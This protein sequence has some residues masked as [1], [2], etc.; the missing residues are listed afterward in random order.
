MSESKLESFQSKCLKSGEVIVVGPL[1]HGLELSAPSAAVLAVDGGCEHAVRFDLSIGDGDSSGFQMDIPASIHKNQSDLALAL[2]I[3]PQG[4]R[5]RLYGFWGQR[6]DHQLTVL[7]EVTRWHQERRQPLTLFGP[8]SERLEILPPGTHQIKHLGLFSLLSLYEGEFS[9]QGQLRYP[10]ER[11]RL[12][13]LS[14]Q[15]LS[16]LGDGEFEVTSSVSFFVYY[17]GVL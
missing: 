16:N 4:V 13:P 9:L 6:L 17:G 5:T 1:A 10:L 11:T 8:T 15:L 7:G 2:E 14:S 12:P 3:I